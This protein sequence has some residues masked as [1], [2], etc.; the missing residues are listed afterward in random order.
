MKKSQRDFK[1]PRY[2]QASPYRRDPSK[3]GT[4]SQKEQR[5]MQPTIGLVNPSQYKQSLELR[6]YSPEHL[7]L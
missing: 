5:Q 1:A 6:G 7:S 3:I 2:N 4:P